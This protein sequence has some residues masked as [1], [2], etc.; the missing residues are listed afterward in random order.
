MNQ[1]C[2]PF[3]SSYRV[4][5]TCLIAGKKMDYDIKTLHTL[6]SKQANAS[7]S[8]VAV[9]HGEQELS[10]KEL[11]R[12]SNQVARVIC[13]RLGK[14]KG[15]VGVYQD[16]S[17]DMI[18]NILAVIKAGQAY[19]PLSKEFPI[20]RMEYI[21]RDSLLNLIICDEDPGLGTKPILIINENLQREAKEFSDDVLDMPASAEDLAYMIYTSGTTGQPKG[22]P[23]KHGGICNRLLWMQDYYNYGQSSANLLK[24]QAGFDVAVLEIFLPLVCGARLILLDEGAQKD[25]N[26][27]ID[28][29][30][31]YK[32]TWLA[33]APIQ[34]NMLIEHSR[35]QECH[36]LYQVSCGIEAWSFSS[37]KK[38]Y[39]ACPNK[40]LFNGYGPT[41]ASVGV[42][43]W[44]TDSNYKF[45]CLT[46]GKPIYNTLLLIVNDQL[47]PVQKGEVG[48]L[49]IAGVCLSP[50]YWNRQDLS[51]KKYIYLNVSGEMTRFYR[52]GDLVKQ[53]PDSNIQ[54]VGRADNQ[55]KI[56]G[57]RVELEEVERILLNNSKI[58]EIA[59][60]DLFEGSKKQL[61][62]FL[63]SNNEA[64]IDQHELL[65]YSRNYLPDVMIPTQWHVVPELPTTING[66]V[67]RNG[68]KGIAESALESPSNFDY[69]SKTRNIVGHFCEKLL[70]SS[71]L[72]TQTSF[73]E[74]GGNSLLA[75]ILLENIKKRF[76]LNIEFSSLLR[77]SSIDQLSALIDDGLGRVKEDSTNNTN[78]Q[79]LSYSHYNIPFYF[80][81][82]CNPAGDISDEQLR[83][84][85]LK[86][87]D[88]C[89]N[90]KQFV[91]ISVRRLTNMNE[92]DEK[93]LMLSKNEEPYLEY[94][95]ENNRYHILF[96]FPNYFNIDYNSLYEAFV[97][98]VARITNHETRG[99]F[100]RDHAFLFRDS[101]RDGGAIV[102][103]QESNEE[104]V[105]DEHISGVLR[106]EL[107]TIRRQI[108]NHSEINQDRAVNRL[109]ID[110]SCPKI[111]RFHP[112]CAFGIIEAIGK[113]IS[114]HRNHSKVFGCHGFIYKR[115]NRL[116]FVESR[117]DLNI[118]I[119][120]NCPSSS[121]LFDRLYTFYGL[122]LERT[123]VNSHPISYIT[124]RLAKHEL[125][126]FS[127]DFNFLKDRREYGQGLNFH[128]VLVY[129]INHHHQYLNAM[130]QTQGRIKI[131]FH[132]VQ[133]FY[134]CYCS[135]ELSVNHFS[136][137]LNSQIQ[138][139]L[140][141]SE[142]NTNLSLITSNLFCDNKNYGINGLTSALGDLLEFV[143]TSNSGPFYAPGVW[144]H[145]HELWYLKE[146]LQEARADMADV[147]V[148]FELDSSLLLLLEDL[149][150]DWFEVDAYFEKALFTQEKKYNRMAL[151]VI[152][153]IIPKEKELGRML[154][155][156]QKQMS[157][158]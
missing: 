138:R 119:G 39:R 79:E 148:Y 87:L 86:A 31:R 53:L 158:N 91:Q 99:Q 56:G 34:L 78:C 84:S 51:D 11:D 73:F 19:V 116:E 68:L 111:S 18:V 46:F 32:I 57:V 58:K 136:L 152:E 8:A 92:L 3:A 13:K 33:V 88:A 124:E 133:E 63:T 48:E 97:N 146:Y 139:K 28:S 2:V 132:D 142:V 147:G 45:Q 4:D 77:N 103:A 50:G 21:L 126:M 127:F 85:I 54:F 149:H 125:C 67:D 70:N 80:V 29:V 112:N 55:I 121:I 47:I 12:R 24:T 10:Y 22:V 137:E 93:L 81:L 27:V 95:R 49:L 151:S 156:L 157:C 7:P 96:H 17:V 72:D 101:L 36:H 43:V 153:K 25:F 69:G 42:A 71:N 135:R 107:R 130:E 131:P 20:Q 14:T 66:K 129:G 83:D 38:F 60:I 134:E 26:R 52:T 110:L 120:S 40:H 105:N 62:A 89:T 114:S 145:S 108:Y 82:H 44:K 76:E 109:A 1:S 16:R 106:A 35:L 150:L 75:I 104:W 113:A 144:S 141:P 6:I 123:L 59:V 65:K 100:T 64:V 15:F 90:E 23:I 143:N 118:S 61:A 5:H 128:P 154:E 94:V 37:V 117:A 74:M 9:C 102:S 41:E 155:L 30:I 140:T 122:T 115:K 98:Q